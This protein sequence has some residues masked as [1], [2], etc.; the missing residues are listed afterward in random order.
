MMGLVDQTG[1]TGGN[2]TGG[3]M[4]GYGD[5]DHVYQV[6]IISSF[7]CYWNSISINADVGWL[8][9]HKYFREKL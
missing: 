2:N 1:W 7:Y 9:Q 8:K 6:R 5:H 3:S 4:A